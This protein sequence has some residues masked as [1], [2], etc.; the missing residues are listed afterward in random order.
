[1]VNTF[2][3]DHDYN[4]SASKLDRARLGKQRVEAEQI[5]NI[6][7]NLHACAELLRLAPFPREDSTQ[8]KIQR[9]A[10]IRYV[11]TNF[12]QQKCYAIHVSSVTGR[13][14]RIEKKINSPSKIITGE[15][16]TV[17]DNIVKHYY[18]NKMIGIGTLEQFV[19]P[20]DF[21]ITTGFSY[22]PAVSMWLGFEES[23]KLYINAHIKVHVDKGYS[24]SMTI[25]KVVGIP[26]TPPWITD[27]IISQFKATLIERE[28][29]RE[30]AGFYIYK[31]DFI[32]AWILDLDKRNTFC[33]AINSFIS[34]GHDW[35][36]YREA[37]PYLLS[38]AK[39]LE[40][41]WP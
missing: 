28:I 8:T 4:I 14:R 21:F 17:E 24:N 7:L 9:D 30:E 32:C 41:G 19:L 34:K 1:M 38:F 36:I 20:E 40:I 23:L 11:M 31:Y 37:R 12:K 10:W 22:H 16:Y 26:K 35:R 29:E 18:E 33:L 5:L 15:T 39:A 25:H 6:L 13:V 3:L 27:T 2:I